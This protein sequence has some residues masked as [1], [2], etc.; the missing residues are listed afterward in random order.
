MTPLEKITI[1]WWITLRFVT[2]YPIFLI[3]G[4]HHDF[5]VSHFSRSCILTIT[6]TTE[7][8]LRQI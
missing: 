6:D 1:T 2:Q 4:F 3:Y 5:I 8:G 7:D